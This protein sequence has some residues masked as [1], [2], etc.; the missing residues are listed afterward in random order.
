MEVVM[1]IMA[2]DRAIRAVAPIEGVSVGAPEDKQS[3]RIDF[4]AQATE[5]ERAA[6]E[7]VVA[8]FDPGL[9][10][11]PQSVTPLQARKA[12]R[13]AGLKPQVDAALVAGGEEVQEAW[14]YA[15]EI[16]RRDPLLL[17]IAAEAGLSAAELDQLF[18]AAAAL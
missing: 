7:A 9:P 11:I 4:A 2:L 5:D 17:Q 1:D 15:I 12:I 3:W 6:A 8:G 18:I 14:D 13:A 16:N 10:E